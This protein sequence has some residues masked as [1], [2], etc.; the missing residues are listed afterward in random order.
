MNQE[1]K[2]VWI[3]ALIQFV[4]I[5]DFMMVMPL[6][7]DL[8]ANLPVTNADIGIICGCY[9]LAVGISGIICAKFIDAYDRKNVAIITIIGLSIGTLSATFATGLYTLVAARVLAGV[10][11]GPAAAIALS[12]II[13]KVP[14]HRRGKAMA[15]VMGSFA[16]SSII[17]IPFG[18]ELARLGDWKTPFHAIFILGCIV[19]V[20]ICCFTPSMTE[21]LKHKKEKISIIE[22]LKN[23][24]YRYA[25]IMMF[26][27]MISTYAIIPPLSAYLQLNLNYPRTSLSFLYLC[28]GLITLLLTQLGGRLSDRIGSLATNLIGTLFY[29]MFLCD[30]F[31]HQPST[32]ILLVFCMFMGMSLLRNVSATTEASKLPPPH[33]RAAFM[34]LFSSV[35]HLGNGVGAFIAASIL[36]TNVSGQLVNMNLVAVISI[37]FALVQPFCL[38]VITNRAK[39]VSLNPV[40]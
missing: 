4:N 38:F 14:M 25:Y 29:V 28:G 7:P 40:V 31:L 12:M 27:A 15:I 18:L 17:A 37:I 1:N 30:G 8:A 13:D 36:T 16:I 5:V 10:F 2:I 35:Q 20:L 9:T 39:Q 6:G 34:S 21:H 26:S 33:E 32:P 23:T 22:L 11:G 24:K 19:L 3:A